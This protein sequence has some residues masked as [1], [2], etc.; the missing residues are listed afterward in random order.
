[1]KK[2]ILLAAISL[3]SFAA[4]AQGVDFGVHAGWNNAKI[5]IKQLK[6]TSHGGYMIGLFARFNA[7]RIYLE[8]ALNFVHKESDVSERSV[9][10]AVKYSS[11]DIPLLLGYYLLDFS[12][13]KL[14]AYIGPEIS[15]LTDRLKSSDFNLRSDKTTWNGKIGAG[16]DIASLSLDIDYGFGITNLGDGQLKK[17]HALTLALGFKIL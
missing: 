4:T 2:I 12:M 9:R 11:V 7:S 3:A 13:V 15:M 1:M 6:V 17:P 8:P 14:R 10:K 5:N 16:L